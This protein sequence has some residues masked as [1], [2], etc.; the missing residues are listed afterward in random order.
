MQSERFEVANIHARQIL[1]CRGDPT[2]QVEVL[3]KG[4]VLGRADVPQGRSTGMYETHVLRDGG[5]EYFGR[6]VRKAIRN[7]DETIAPSLKGVDVRNQKE[8]DAHLIELD[9]TENKSKLGA[10]A[11]VG[12]SLAVARTA[13]NSLDVPLYAYVGGPAACVLPAPLLNYIN[14]GKLAATDLDFQEHIIIPVGAKSFSEAMR[15]GVEVYYCLGQMLAEKYTKYVLNTADEGGYTPPMRDPREAFE[16]E[17]KAIEE[18]GYGKEFVLGLDSAATHLYNKKMKK[19]TFMGK[20][21][22]REKLIDF[23]E[24]L[25]NAYPIVS[26]EDPLEEN[27]FEGF[28]E[29]TESLGIQI[30]GDDLF[31]TN[32]K[33]L[34][35][36]IELGAANALLWKVNQVGT[37]S[38]A[39]DAANMAFRNGY[40]VQVSERSGQTEDTWLADLAVALNAG[41]IKTGAPC[42]SERVAQ[43]NR[44]FQ[45]EEA[46]GKS[47]RYPGRQ[48]RKPV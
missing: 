17:L 15:K 7:V 2:V 31:V 32:V 23:Y 8:I 1:D 9:G 22:T 18:L 29:L 47:A 16:A 35:K 34:R 4:G 24:D 21:I 10:N 38:E 28:K 48:F 46:L 44:L 43:Y 5:T 41:Q 19:Y 45:I 14:G 33:R 26:I 27:D 20:K 40:G 39:L 42:R 3:T 12:V 36:G 25:V 37:L 30:V 13:A 11:I 6:G